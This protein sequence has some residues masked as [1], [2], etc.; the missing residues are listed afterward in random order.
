MSFCFFIFSLSDWYYLEVLILIFCTQW[1]IFQHCNCLRKYTTNSLLYTSPPSHQGA[2]TESVHLIKWK[3][4]NNTLLLIIWVLSCS[5]SSCNC[6]GMKIF[7]TANLFRITPFIWLTNSKISQF[8][9]NRLWQSFPEKSPT[10]SV[11]FHVDWT[12]L[13]MTFPN[14]SKGRQKNLTITPLRMTFCWTVNYTKGW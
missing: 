5:K 3:Y 12:F 13:Q 4:K 9:K 8:Q 7:N 6:I 1:E 14:H 11:Y 10:S 2:N